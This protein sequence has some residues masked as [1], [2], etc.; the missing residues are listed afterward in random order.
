MKCKGCN[1]QITTSNYCHKCFSVVLRSIQLSNGVTMTPLR[2]KKDV[3][4]ELNKRCLVCNGDATGGKLYNDG[5]VVCTRCSTT[6]VHPRFVKIL[7]IGETSPVSP[8]VRPM[9]LEEFIKAMY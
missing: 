1:Q 7:P 5:T 3:E 9:T 8:A 2:R 6:G 4:S